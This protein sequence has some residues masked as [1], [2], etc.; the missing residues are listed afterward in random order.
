MEE[1]PGSKFLA[2]RQAP[3]CVYVSCMPTPLDATPTVIR[4]RRVPT[5]CKYLSPVPTSLQLARQVLGRL[6]R[7]PCRQ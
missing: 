2:E 3:E 5:R 6:S 4:A 7:S 1:S